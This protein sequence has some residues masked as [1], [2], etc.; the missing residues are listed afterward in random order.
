MG[1]IENHSSLQ[2]EEEHTRAREFR[3]V[4]CVWSFLELQGLETNSE[5]VIK[6]YE[7]KMV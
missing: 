6:N 4:D 2:R 7:C 1:G 5:L 3:K